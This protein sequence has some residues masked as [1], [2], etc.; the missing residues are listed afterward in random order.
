MFKI[1]TRSMA[2][3]IRYSLKSL[4]SIQDIRK[5]IDMG[6]ITRGL[7]IG[8]ANAGE[9]I[10]NKA[11]QRRDWENRTGNLHDSYVSAVFVNGVLIDGEKSVSVA[12]K[13]GK[14]ENI[15]FPNSIRFVDEGSRMA[16]RAVEVGTFGTKHYSG[17]PIQTSGHEEALEFLRAYKQ[18]GRGKMDKIQLVVAAAMYYSGILESKGY[19]VISNIEWDL[20]DLLRDG[21]YAEGLLTTSIP[22]DGMVH[23]LDV[24]APG[25]TRFSFA[26]L[27]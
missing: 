17:D 3:L 19:T 6:R 13:N 23:R 14:T 1:Q 18:R 16:T 12:G 15:V 2:K 5:M 7:V 25:S 9:D 8:L 24:V 20:I 21:I 11:Y 4:K 10:I 22:V 26:N 27:D